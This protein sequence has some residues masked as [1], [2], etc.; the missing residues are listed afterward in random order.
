MQTLRTLTRATYIVFFSFASLINSNGLCEPCS[1]CDGCPLLCEWVPHCRSLTDSAINPALGLD[2]I[3]VEFGSC[4]SDCSQC[5]GN[6][7]TACDDISRANCVSN[8]NLQCVGVDCQLNCMQCEDESQCAVSEA[9]PIGCSYKHGDDGI[10]EC[11]PSS[12]IDISS[13]IFFTDEPTPGPTG[14]TTHSP[15]KKCTKKKKKKKKGWK[16]KGWK[17]H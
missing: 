5:V 13:T 14:M 10:R 12:D 15:T 3:C 6:S 11:V 1:N 2:H 17:K 8:D 7:T 9:E 16:N 4:D